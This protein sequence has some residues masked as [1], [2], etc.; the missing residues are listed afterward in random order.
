MNG[1]VSKEG[2]TLDLEAM[3]RVGVGG[4]QN[5]DAGT[6]I[7]E[8]PVKYLSPEWLELKKHTIREADRLGLEFTMHNCPGWSS[9]G[10]PWITPELAM[11][12]ITW[13]EASAKGGKRVKMTV[14]KPFTNLNH[15]R[16]IAVLAYPSLQG[17]APL[18][19][20]VKSVTSSS[21]PV[22]LKQLT[23]EQPQGVTV[24][25]A[26]EG[27]PAFLQ[28]ELKQLYE[29]RSLTFIVSPA[30]AGGWGGGQADSLV[31]EAS[32][33][34]MQFRE[35]SAITSA[36]DM[37]R[38]GEE[39]LMFAEFPAVSARYFRITSPKER[40]IAQV[41]FSGSPR[42]EDWLKKANYKFTGDGVADTGTPISAASTIDLNRVVDITRFMDKN[43]QLKWKAP[44]GNWTI[45]RMGF[46]PLGTLNRS[47]PDTGIGL[48]CDKYSAEA[49]T[50]HFNRSVNLP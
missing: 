40:R 46:T 2:I 24:Q 47:A 15:Y 28:F 33:D 1:N 30:I 39:A 7:P 50:F 42:L 5:F 41:R 14:P 43:G 45:L 6:G 44:R 9:S 16:D 35:V 13:S 26:A 34:G 36:A 37:G 22:N 4:F 8:G 29:A 18:Q 3:Q 49:I 11:Q 32:D 12:Q 25:P 20:M 38:S 10:G 21:S 23:G 17:E 19:D 48:E 27:Q 31:L